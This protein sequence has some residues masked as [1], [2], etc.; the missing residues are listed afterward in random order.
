MS[1]SANEALRLRLDLMTVHDITAAVQLY[2]Q[3]FAAAPWGESYADAEIV[4]R[5]LSHYA[6]PLYDAWPLV[7]SL[8][9]DV[10][11]P[12][13]VLDLQSGEMVVD[14]NSL[15]QVH[16]QESDTSAG[17]I[18]TAQTAS[19]NY[20]GLLPFFAFVARVDEQLV[21][22]CCASLKP[23]MEGMQ[24]TLDEFCV[25]PAFQGRGVGRAFLQGIE[26][27]LQ[28]RGVNA[29]ITTTD[30]QY[31]GGHFYHKC[32]YMPMPRQATLAKVLS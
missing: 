29:M 28:E 17:D 2:Q 14:P 19:H 8:E 31:Q 4:A 3:S 26:L 6:Q 24:A 20:S 18:S 25:A 22:L 32:G 5:Y 9:I 21:A 15:P 1:D 27:L 11:P 13:Y 7:Q 23:W 30:P 10:I 12:C 16:R